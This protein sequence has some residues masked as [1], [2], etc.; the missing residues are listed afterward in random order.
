MK[1]IIW[2]ITTIVLA[3][4]N[5][6]QDNCC[7]SIE[8][9]NKNQ[10]TNGNNG[11]IEDC[12]LLQNQPNPFNSVTV[13]SYFVP[14]ENASASMLFFDMN[15]K[16]ILTKNLDI[17]ADS[18]RISSG[19]LMPGMYFYTLIVNSVEVDTKKMILTN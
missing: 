3:I 5:F 8:P 9:Q 4:P 19:E 14:I 7:N 16:L 13:I 18:L 12:Y 11:N 6:A 15:G 1:I 10:D 17:N 2:I